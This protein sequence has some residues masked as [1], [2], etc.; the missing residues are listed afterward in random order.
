MHQRT[1]W[2]AAP[3]CGIHVPIR[4]HVRPFVRFSYPSNYSASKIFHD[5]FRDAK[6]SSE[7]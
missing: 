4:S 6:L 2:S 3:A 1:I 7:L 5:F